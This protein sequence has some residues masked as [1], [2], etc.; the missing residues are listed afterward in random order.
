M[1]WICWYVLGL[2]RARSD[3]WLTCNQ[4]VGNNGLTENEERAH[5][6]IWAMAKSPLI[7]GCDL[8]KIKTSSLNILKNKV[9][10]PL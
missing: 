5:M 4:F 9:S 10:F 7:I 2:E 3:H 1:I 8:S 6:S